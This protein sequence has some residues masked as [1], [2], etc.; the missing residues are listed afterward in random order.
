MSKMSWTEE[1]YFE[2]F[3]T[4]KNLQNCFHVNLREIEHIFSFYPLAQNP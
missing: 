3:W 2:I 1:L 4:Y